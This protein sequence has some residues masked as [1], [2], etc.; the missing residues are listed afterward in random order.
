M[1]A[2]LRQAQATNG[3]IASL[4]MGLTALKA[5]REA[6][7]AQISTLEAELAGVMESGKKLQ[8]DHA[9]LSPVDE[10]PLLDALTNIA[11]DAKVLARA[12]Q[13]RTAE[14][15]LLAAQQNSE[16][17]TEQIKVIDREKREALA[18]AN[19][20][21]G[22]E[23][24]KDGLR[25][26]GQPLEQASLAEKIGVSVALGV[27]NDPAWRIMLV[28]EGSSLDSEHMRLLH[29]LAIQRHA[30]FFVEVASDD[31]EGATVIIEDG[32][33]KS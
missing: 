33:V 6:L 10:R 14:G 7:K 30:Q 29:D 12:E 25:L 22:L 18:S 1:E 4:E 17:L 16:T 23:V 28:R 8:H 13:K 15:E 5:K 3:Q 2:R 21:E 19:L 24:T 9:Q 20:P 26:N 32:M 11:S 27:I 31:G